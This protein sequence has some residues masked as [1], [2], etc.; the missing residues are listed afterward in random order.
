MRCTGGGAAGVGSRS[1]PDV[2][3]ALNGRP[4]T[5]TRSFPLVDRETG[6]LWSGLSG[7]AVDGTPGGRCLDQIP[8]TPVFWFAWSDFYPET[9]LR[10]RSPVALANRAEAAACAVQHR[11]VNLDD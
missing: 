2:L 1:L 9:A 5:P 10:R 11:L 7:L 4:S 3:P 8:S 6:T